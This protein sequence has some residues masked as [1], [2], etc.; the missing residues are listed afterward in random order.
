[1]LSSPNI[2]IEELRERDA[3]RLQTLV[4]VERTR[5]LVR[6]FPAG[7]PGDDG[8]AIVQPGVVDE[9]GQPGREALDRCDRAAEHL[10]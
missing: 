5:E 8:A 7:Q 10:C 2:L 3:E 1:M 9:M 4:P 6:V